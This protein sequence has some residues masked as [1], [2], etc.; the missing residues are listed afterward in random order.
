MGALL[1]SPNKAVPSSVCVMGL[2]ACTTM[3]GL[4]RHG[5]NCENEKLRSN[6]QIKQ[7]TS[8]CLGCDY[9]DHLSSPGFHSVL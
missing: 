1:H 8:P 9:S 3:F 6:E 5:N 4:D 7:L 2:E